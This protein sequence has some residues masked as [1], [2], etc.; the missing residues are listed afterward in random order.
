MTATAVQVLWG[1]CLAVAAALMG[2]GIELHLDGAGAALSYPLVVGG[3]VLLPA[4]STLL[5][6]IGSPTPPPADG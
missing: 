4:A 5:E 6:R 3:I 1:L 2:L